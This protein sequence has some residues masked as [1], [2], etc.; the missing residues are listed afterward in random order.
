MKLSKANAFILLTALAL[1]TLFS[2]CKKT[3]PA[4]AA[5]TNNITVG[6]AI[7]TATTNGYSYKCS[8]TSS[9]R[10]GVEFIISSTDDHNVS[11]NATA[12]YHGLAIYFNVGIPTVQTYTL[13]NQTASS[14]NYAQYE[15][16]PTNTYTS[17]H[18]DS[19][20]TG[21]VVITKSDPV[22]KKISG[23][24][25]F[26]AVQYSPPGT[27]VISVTNGSFTDVVYQ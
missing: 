20:R 1:T 18:T 14:T 12:P 23:T 6:T 17:Y 22:A 24:F 15:E 27:A 8:T 16:G 10:Q 4:P 25:S 7:L 5:T 3:T 11:G 2:A 26:N 13:T 9:A 19:T 21:T